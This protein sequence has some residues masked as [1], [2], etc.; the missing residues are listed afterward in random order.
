MS[1]AAWQRKGF[2][3]DWP[4]GSASSSAETPAAGRPAAEAGVEGFETVA[5]MQSKAFQ[6]GKQG[7]PGW[8]LQLRN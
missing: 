1:W 3:F 6:A 8:R 5:Q 2:R 7:I 4:K